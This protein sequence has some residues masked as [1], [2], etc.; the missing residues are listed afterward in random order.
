M[1]T[2]NL[3][4]WNMHLSHSEEHYHNTLC[5][6]LMSMTYDYEAVTQPPPHQIWLKYDPEDPYQ[7]FDT[8]HLLDSLHL[9]KNCWN[10]LHMKTPSSWSIVV[11]LDSHPL[12]CLQ[13]QWHSSPKSK[14]Y[15]MHIHFITNIK[16][17]GSQ[18]HVC[19]L[20]LGFQLLFTLQCHDTT[21]QLLYYTF[22]T[23]VVFPSLL[24]MFNYTT[25]PLKYSPG[26]S[27]DVLF[28]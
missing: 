11:S 20:L 3:V 4:V 23:V 24:F 22:Q 25:A 14:M 17:L 28:T 8:I 15:R 13:R 7:N 16:G 27:K 21:L 9:S 26:C 19:S 2:V 1:S 12:D 10:Q 18:H 5:D 6:N